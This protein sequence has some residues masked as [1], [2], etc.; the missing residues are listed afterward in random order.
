MAL[1]CIYHRSKF[2]KGR[3]QLNRAIAYRFDET[4]CTVKCQM[5]DLGSIFMDIKQIQFL[6]LA[7]DIGNLTFNPTV[8]LPDSGRLI[9]AIDR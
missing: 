1:L 2:V 3:K 8:T 6:H 7:V 4:S 9:V 5:L